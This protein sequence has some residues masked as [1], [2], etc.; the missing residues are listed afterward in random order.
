MFSPVFKSVFYLF[1]IPLVSSQHLAT[2]LLTAQPP[3]ES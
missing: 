2:H 3:L 1:K